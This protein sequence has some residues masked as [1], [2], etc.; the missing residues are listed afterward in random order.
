MLT[1]GRAG[2]EEYDRIP[3]KQDTVCPHRQRAYLEENRIRLL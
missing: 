2:V 1:I 3:D